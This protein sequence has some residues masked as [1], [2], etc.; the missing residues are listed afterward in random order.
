MRDVRVLWGGDESVRQLRKFSLSPHAK[1]ICFVD[2]FSFALFDAGALLSYN[3]VPELVHQFYNDAFSFDQNACSSP[4]MIIWKGQ[5]ESIQKA[6]RIFWGEFLNQIKERTP[7][8]P[9]I[10]RMEKVIKQ[11]ELSLSNK[12][13]IL[14]SHS[15]YINRVWF[16]E[17]IEIPLNGHPGGGLFYEGFIERLNDLLPLLNRKIQ[18][19]SYF[20]IDRKKFLFLLANSVIKELIES[21]QLVQ[22]WNLTITGMVMIY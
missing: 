8:L 6:Q 10:S 12:C 17:I 18:T 16:D 13:K 22:H 5:S 1:E 21:Y 14:P 20:G 15:A 4:R 2:K 7:K 19:I 11:F 9:L 3:R